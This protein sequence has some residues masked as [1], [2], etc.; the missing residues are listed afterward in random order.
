MYEIR[1]YNK[2]HKDQLIELWVDVAVNEYGF[3]NWKDEISILNENDYEKILVAVFDG[4]VV[5]SIAYKKID[6]NV[7]ELKRVY[8]YKEHR[9]NKIAKKLYNEIIKLIKENNYKKIMVET[10]KSFE[11]GRRFYEKNNF[12]L[13]NVQD[14][15]YYYLLE[16]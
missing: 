2:K 12:I 7:A 11:S 13:Q 4:K 14:E 8:V 10:W 16:L 6:D 15:V 3:K 5:G 9:G 1:E